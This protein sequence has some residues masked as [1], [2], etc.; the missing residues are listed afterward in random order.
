MM[1]GELWGLTG[2]LVAKGKP[3]KLQPSLPEYSFESLGLAV[4]E[5]SVAFQEIWEA[6]LG[7]KRV[8][9]ISPAP[10]QSIKA[11]T[12]RYADGY[13]DS[14][15]LRPIDSLI[16]QTRNV[17]DSFLNAPMGWHPQGQKVS[18]AEQVAIINR[19]KQ[20]VND[21]LTEISKSRLWKVPQPKWQGAYEPRGTG[22]TF[23]RKQRVRDI[24]VLQVPV[25]QS[26]SDRW[27]QTWV[28]EI[29]SMLTRALET[30]EAEQNAD[31]TLQ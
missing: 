4:R 23:T 12:W 17:L 13:F 5:A 16:S 2:H 28:E 6:R 25:P 18:E 19:M 24:L 8:E 21:A 10:W 7:Y 30:L 1:G 11:M 20:L 27:A 29:K 31:G 14:F 15:W 22:S 3:Q 9:G 26:I